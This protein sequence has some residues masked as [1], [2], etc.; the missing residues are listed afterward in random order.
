MGPGSATPHPALRDDLDAYV[1]YH[2]VLDPRAVHVGLPSPTATVIIAFDDPLDVSWP[3]GRSDRP[4]DR[5]QNRTQAWVSASGLH[6]RPALI[7]TH[8]IQHGIQL[9]LTPVGVRRLLGVPIAALGNLTVDHADLPGGIPADLHE[10][11][12]EASWQERYAL[13]EAHLLSVADDRSAYR[14][15]DITT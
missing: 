8:G 13:V 15:R 12:A 14:I 11:L 1:G 10:R 3:T 7:H 6:E 9:G 5:A 2:H 4:S